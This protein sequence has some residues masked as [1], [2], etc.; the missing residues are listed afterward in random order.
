[1]KMANS[2][3]ALGKDNKLSDQRRLGGGNAMPF[4]T[5]LKVGNKC[6]TPPEG[7]QKV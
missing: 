6:N 3:R 7:R 4:G 2:L 1:M 5:A